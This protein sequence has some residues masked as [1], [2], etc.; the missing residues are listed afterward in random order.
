MTWKEEDSKDEDNVSEDSEDICDA[1]GYVTPPPVTT[2]D[3]EDTDTESDDVSTEDSSSE[4]SDAEA[5]HRSRMIDLM[6]EWMGYIYATKI[7]E[8][9]IYLRNCDGN[10]DWTH[11]RFGAFKLL[12]Q[13]EIEDTRQ[14]ILEGSILIPI[15]KEETHE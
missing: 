8:E 2:T 11:S 5:R 9:L 4:E 15:S 7:E 12:C 3:K 13:E 6:L 14:Q 10:I 1:A